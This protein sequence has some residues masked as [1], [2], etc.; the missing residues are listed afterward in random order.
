ME[1]SPVFQ[2]AAVVD[3]DMKEG[4][5][6]EPS[7]MLSLPLDSTAR[8]EGQM[9]DEVVKGPEPAIGHQLAEVGQQS[10]K[11]VQC[12][13][14]PVKITGPSTGPAF[15]RKQS[16]V[17]SYFEKR[18]QGSS[19]ECTVCGE[20]QRYAGNTTNMS[21]HIVK[22]HSG[23]QSGLLAPDEGMA[24]SPAAAKERK[25][26]KRKSFSRSL[27]WR[28][29]TRVAG[30]KKVQCQLCMEHYAYCHNTTN[31]HLHLKSKHSDVLKADLDCEAPDPGVEY[32]VNEEGDVTDSMVSV[33]ICP[34]GDSSQLEGTVFVVSDDGQSVERSESV[35]TA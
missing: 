30:E 24:E 8:V 14:S 9:A 31:L 18:D 32:I 28:F 1:A 7:L 17:W 26:S 29:F 11:N 35:L 12:L 21:R 25:L 34:V 19:V 16:K 5:K 23:K 15:R 33:E 2:Q 13:A 10:G 20:V 3:V 27:V 6:E 4:C 22:R